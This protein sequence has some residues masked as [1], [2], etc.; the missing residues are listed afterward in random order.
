MKTNQI[1]LHFIVPVFRN[2]IGSTFYFFLF[3]E[4]DRQNLIYMR[5]NTDAKVSTSWDKQKIRIHVAVKIAKNH[6]KSQLKLHHVI[7]NEAL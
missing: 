6:T 7:Q 3:S 2:S 5:I 4:I 1:V